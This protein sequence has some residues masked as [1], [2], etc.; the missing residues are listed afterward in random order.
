MKNR[1]I[2]IPERDAFPLAKERFIS[3]CGFD[4]E[5]KKHQ[6]M[7]KMGLT[8]LEQ[9]IQGI[10]IR[11]LVSFYG[12]EA[13]QNGKILAED[14]EFSCNYFQQIPEDAIEGVYFYMLTAGEC[15]FSSEENIM[16]FLYA[17]IWGTN[18]VDAGIRL[19]TEKIEEDMR[20]RFPGRSMYLSDE[21]GPGYF[22]MP[23]IE[24]K[25]FFEI[26][27]AD[28]IGVRVKDSGLMIPQ[29]SCDGFYLVFNRPGLKA[30]PECMRCLGN[31]AGC[32]FCAVKASLDTAGAAGA[33]GV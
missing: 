17:D 20:N 14:M 28:E 22:G 8:V 12:K 26:L 11:A 16:D 33:A 19:L 4:L 31:A 25:K 29:K 13:V 21:F 9:G 7:M 30:E 10:D 32:Q 1:K 18:Y 5:T 2:S 6:R 3:T 27:Q 15:Y 24:S 23:V